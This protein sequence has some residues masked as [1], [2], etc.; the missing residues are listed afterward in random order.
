MSLLTNLA[1]LKSTLRD[2]A[3]DLHFD[4]KNRTIAINIRK[5]QINNTAMQCFVTVIEIKNTILTS[6]KMSY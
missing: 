3:N 6:N 1:R 2:F 5:N 4:D